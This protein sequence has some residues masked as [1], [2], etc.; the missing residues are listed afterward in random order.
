M[1]VNDVC[2]RGKEIDWGSM[3]SCKL[4]IKPRKELWVDP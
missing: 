1:D 2:M 3:A 4:R